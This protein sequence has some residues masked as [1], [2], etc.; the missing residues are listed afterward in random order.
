MSKAKQQRINRP[1]QV[2][3][4]KTGELRYNGQ[5]MIRFKHPTTGRTTRRVGGA[6]YKE[7]DKKLRGI[8]TDIER[9]VW[10]DAVEVKREK[11]K[12][13]QDIFKFVK[14]WGDIC[15]RFVLHYSDRAHATQRNLKHTISYFSPDD[16]PA[17]IPYDMPIFKLT[18]S[19]IAGIRDKVK[20]SKLARGTRNL[21]L[22]NLRMICAWATEHPDIPIDENPALNLKRFKAG[23]S[24]IQGKQADVQ[25]IG[26][27]EVFDKNDAVKM[28]AYAHSHNTPVLAYML[29]CALLS[30]MRKGEL[31]GLLWAYVDFDRRTIRVCRNYDRKGTK[32][33]EFEE[34]LVPITKELLSSLKVWKTQTPYSKDSDPVF[35]SA[36]GS[37]RKPSFSWATFV[38]RVAIGAGVDKPNMSRWGH[39]TRHFFATQWLLRKGSDALLAKILGHRDTSLIHRVYSHFRP[40]DLIE[41]I[42]EL[43]FNLATSEAT[44]TVLK[45]DN[46]STPQQKES[47][48]SA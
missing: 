24:G 33:G 4:S 35:P 28:L 6:T 17:M 15:D 5:W 1:F 40:N 47:V 30:G 20:S 44:L 34:R 22:I 41:A 21:H 3:D 10:K 18:E 12:H 19:L 43:D 38:H 8:L 46:Q 9:G 14:T 16:K 31:C 39:A 36:D 2:K 25:I 37:V 32:S 26:R 42:D 29:E 23:G 27:N 45:P 48:T 13:K 7:A 11:K